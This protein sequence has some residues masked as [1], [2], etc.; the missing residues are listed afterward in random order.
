VSVQIQLRRGT[1][2]A[3]T[4]AN[5]I[6]AQGEMGIETDTGK[7]K[8]GDGSNTWTA[9]SYASV[10]GSLIVK[11][12]DSVV[13]GAATTIDFGHGIDGTSSPAGEA[14]IAVDETELSFSTSAMSIGKSLALLGDISPT[15]LSGNTN[16]WAPTG[17]AD[18]AIIRA[19]ASGAYNLTGLTGG[20]D[21][22]TIVLSNVGATYSITLQHD[23]TSTA[24]NRFYCPSLSDLT[25]PPGGSVLLIYDSTISRWHILGG[26]GGVLPGVVAFSADETINLTGNTSNLA[27]GSSTSV[28]RLTANASYTL[29]GI[30][31]GSDG[32]V[33]VVMNADTTDTITLKHNT[34]STAANQFYCPDQTDLA[35]A[36]FSAVLMSYDYTAQRWRIV[37]PFSLAT[38]APA[39]VGTA[40]VGT[41][42]KAARSDHVHATGAA[43]PSTQ[44]FG[45]SA[46]TG[47]GPA[48]AMTDH[49]HAMMSHTHANTDVTGTYALSGDISPTALAGNTN[50]WNPTSLSTAST[51]RMDASAAY[52]LTGL[53]GG[54]DGRIIVLHNIS[55]YTITMKHDVTSTAAYRFYCPNNVDLPLQ[56]KASAILRYDS[57]SSRWRVIGGTG[58]STSAGSYAA[59]IGDNTNT[60]YTVTHSLG[61]KD[62]EVYVYNNST[63][64]QVEPDITNVDT[65][66]ITV[67]FDT[68]PT[69]NQFRVVVLG[70]TVGQAAATLP[71]KD[72]GTL[73]LAAP[74]AL[75]FKGQLVP[76]QNSTEVDIVMQE[77]F[78]AD[79]SKG[80]VLTTGTGTFRWYND[81]GRTLTFQSVRASV[82]TAPTGATIIVDVNKDGTT[83]YTTQGN[84][85]TIATSTNTIDD[86]TAPDVTTI[87]DNSF[88]TIDIDQ[89][90]STVAGSDLTVQ[91]W[92]KG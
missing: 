69:T 4:S 25:L 57:T 46:V 35:L 31:G 26:D 13:D 64:A 50:D 2:A 81:T 19:S 66:S 21:G 90:G 17:L 59:S 6:L 23:V 8:F 70:G 88:L 84:R 63:G 36:A 73:V 37:A 53:Q 40:A 1:A 18:A 15:E 54:A 55:A 77:L 44:A 79:F 24:A 47:S 49:K 56:Q 74:S 34:G 22:R 10:T 91:V 86:T 82:G 48:A 33:L 39:N 89:I 43:T 32:R 30:T 58:G 11:V 27:L 3:W 65:S 41:A 42:V 51:I 7:F 9:L 83:I 38:A 76:T 5:P 20:A 92:M 62:V 72:D 75:N 45:D 28:L 60:S 80:G 71:I 16:D 61:T 87:A 52:D 67:A 29:D 85:P 14:N 12:D 68:A 78:H